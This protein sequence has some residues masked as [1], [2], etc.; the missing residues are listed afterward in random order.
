ME[1]SKF[2]SYRTSTN[3]NRIIVVVDKFSKITQYISIINKWSE[4]SIYFKYY[5]ET[6]QPAKNQ[7]KTLHSLLSQTDKQIERV[8]QE[9]E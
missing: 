9:M 7:T 1:Y 8:N 6:L 4:T 3:L 5:D 2:K